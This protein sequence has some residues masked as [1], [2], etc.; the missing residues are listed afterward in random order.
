MLLVSDYDGT[1]RN[2]DD[3]IYLNNEEI[4]K[5]MKEGNTFVLSSGRSYTSL[6]KEAMDYGIPYNYLG[7]N[8]GNCLFDSNGQLLYS[9]VIDKDTLKS[10]A[11]VKMCDLSNRTRYYYEKVVSDEYYPTRP[12]NIV[13]FMINK[14]YVTEETVE[15][16]EELRSK[17]KDYEISDYL[18]QDTLYFLL[19][20]KMVSKATGVEYL[21]RS[22]QM[23]K[24]DIFTVGDAINDLEM[25]REYNGYQIG[26]KAALSEVAID[27]YDT[28]HHLVKDIRGNKIKRRY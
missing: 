20:K 1:Y 10:D 9:S 19:R 3:S 13:I 7:T 24:K 27:S 23:P 4:E 16:L 14:R 28:V 25:I 21:G 11:F 22:L 17:A 5:F 8:N 15:I 26:N 2:N 12:I 6:S 18:Y